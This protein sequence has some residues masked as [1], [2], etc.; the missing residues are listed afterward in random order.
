[1]G[2]TVA[3]TGIN[4]YIAAPLLKRL[5]A[6]QNIDRIIGIDVTPWRG[7]SGKVSFFREDIRSEAITGILQGVDVVYHLA[8]IVNEIQDKSQTLDINIEGS[9]NVF[10]ACLDNGVKKVVFISSNTAYGAHPESPLYQNEE[11]PL[12]RNEKSYY[13]TSKIQVESFAREFFSDHPEITFTILRP[14]LV[15]GPNINNMFSKVFSSKVSAMAVGASP[16]IHFVHE[17]DLGEAMYLCLIHDL[18]G[19]YNVGANDAMSA[20]KCF[21]L[22]GVKLAP[23]PAFALRPMADVAFKLRLLPM[24]SGWVEVS[25]HTI[26]SDNH[27][28]RAATG[29]EPKYSSEETFASYLDRQRQFKNKKLKHKYLTF[30]LKKRPLALFGLGLMHNL[31]RVFSIPGL[32]MI[33]PWMD[34]KKN[35]MTYLPINQDL[36]AQE[37]VL[38]AEVVHQFIDESTHHVVMNECGCRF[39]HN[40][41]NHTHDV[42]CLFMGET[43]L[44]MPKGLSRKVT[45][46]EA[47]A[48]VE[49]AISAGLV[50]MTGKVRVDNDIFLVKDRQKLLSVCFCC[51]CCCMMRYFRHVPGEHLDQVM[52]PVEGLE[53]HVTDDCVGCGTCIETCAFD[54]ITIQNGKAV[55]GDI[56]R[57]CGRCATACPNG[58]VTIQLKNPKAVKDVK[59]RISQYMEVN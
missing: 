29:W 5:D 7:G 55:H 25:S 52:P 47:H 9:K 17:D 43:A 13:N 8:F 39:A 4:S 19:I 26:F 50:P 58:A 56:C 24:S 37:E 33:A 16:H 6:D 12:H 57:K 54:A 11:S 32:R 40:C 48:H 15:F 1:M 51:H 30:L 59:H 21:R 42:G 38:L 22:A 28:F 14:A 18:S 20:R 36:I 27:K 23:M 35:S 34:P 3:V 10:R 31:F 2:M 49:R 46:E 41:Q 45:R 53:I 44:D